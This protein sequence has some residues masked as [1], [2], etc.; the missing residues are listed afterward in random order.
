MKTMRRKRLTSQPNIGLTASV[1]RAV[2]MKSQ[3]IASSPPRMPMASRAG[4]ITPMRGEDAAEVERRHEQRRD[5]VAPH[6]EKALHR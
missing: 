1:T 6:V 4:R 5:L 3:R 2:P